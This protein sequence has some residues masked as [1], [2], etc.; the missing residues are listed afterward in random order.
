MVKFFSIIIFAIVYSVI[1]FRIADIMIFTK[2]LQLTKN[3]EQ[4]YERGKIFDRN[5]QLL[6]TNINSYSLFV[7]AKKIKYNRYKHRI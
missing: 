4:I 3:E 5:G 7:N 6:S 2:S 1:F